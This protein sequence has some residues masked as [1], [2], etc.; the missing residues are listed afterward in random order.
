MLILFSNFLL[1]F[2][3]FLIKVKFILFKSLL[4][5]LDFLFV[6]VGFRI[7]HL[8]D[9]WYQSERLRFRDLQKIYVPR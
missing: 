9:G 8:S 1:K 5:S 2:G 7:E 3:V 6:P 4:E